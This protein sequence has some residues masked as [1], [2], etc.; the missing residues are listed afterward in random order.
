MDNFSIDHIV[1]CDMEKPFIFISYSSED[2]EYVCRDVIT[3]QSRGY[4][5]WLDE[6]NLDKSEAS[7]KSNALEAIHDYDCKLALF[8]VSKS[9]LTSLNCLEELL[10][11][12]SETT[13]S[14][15][16]GNA[17]KFLAIETDMV[18]IID[19]F[20]ADLYQRVSNSGLDKNEI[21]QKLEALSGFKKEIFNTNEKVRI[22]CR[23]NPNRKSDYYNEIIRYF[24]NGTKNLPI[25]TVSALSPEEEK[26][27]LNPD[28]KPEHMEKSYEDGSHYDGE[29]VKGLRHGNGTMY[30]ATGEEYVGQWVLDKKYYGV[31]EWAANSFLDLTMSDVYGQD[32]LEGSEKNSSENKT[33]NTYAKDV[34]A[35]PAK[36]S[37]YWLDELPHGEG[38]MNYT[39]GD[40][41]KGS[42]K[43]GLHDG[44]GI[45][46][47][48]DG[49]R[50]EGDWV[51]G[52]RH[53]K[54]KTMWS[55]GHIY[56]G[57]YLNNKKDGK[58]YEV[59]SDRS[60]YEGEY[61][62]DKYNGDGTLTMADGSIYKG[63]FVAGLFHGQGEMK[64]GNG[65]HFKGEWKEGSF[66]GE[67]IY[68]TQ[69]GD[70][71]EG[72]FVEMKLQGQGTHQL[73]DGSKYNGDFLKGKYNGRGTM[74]YYNGD[75]YDG[76]WVEGR[77][78]GRG[79]L[80]FSDGSRF[81]GYFNYN[82]IAGNGE[83]RYHNGDIYTGAW[84]NGK[85]NGK[86]KLT[87]ADGKIYEGYFLD[88]VIN[89]KG[90]MLYPDGEHYDG[91]WVNAIRSGKGKLSLP[92]GRKYEGSFSYNHINGRGK[93]EYPNGEFYEGD[94][95]EDLR[96]GNGILI[97]A[98]GRRYKG[99]FSSDHAT[100][101]GT[102]TWPKEK[103]LRALISYDRYE[104]EVKDG[105]RHGIGVMT[106]ADES[107]YDGYWADDKRHG[108]GTLRK[109]MDE[110]A[111][112]I[113]ISKIGRGLMNRLS[114]SKIAG[115]FGGKK[116]G[117]GTI[118]NSENY[119]I[120]EGEWVN[121]LQHG[122]GEI[123]YPDGTIVRGEWR[124]G[125]KIM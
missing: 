55:D 16:M 78:E 5:I 114:D 25:K 57:Q 64:Y 45:F 91:D 26:A 94:W 92:D 106:W 23:N 71:Y 24:P 107:V 18:G 59:F 74:T 39:N 62:E 100:G 96:V 73:A 20:Q 110:N 118:K 97:F 37:G 53:G 98:N 124:D 2:Y 104:G 56:E 28:I 82:A 125:E 13:R 58:G 103:G 119:E 32:N 4:N 76:D 47:E 84:N 122:Q 34:A 111:S 105:L 90:S 109:P 66:E 116:P 113:T 61:L 75:V 11:L 85:R 43:Q 27:L 121:D 108:H 101:R 69:N 99:T 79:I 10:E 89:G 86:G 22:L 83:M 77:R 72:I 41:Y 88:D 68:T 63:R 14:V 93:M 80:T 35:G 65:A 52:K 102:I 21:H 81:D 15:R 17:V 112:M 60:S 1:P 29:S 50:Y 67:G 117:M 87:Y 54:G 3:F 8:Y 12:S 123:R 44:Y 9:S 115:R 48:A 36:Y 31:Q 7:W 6:P 42:F 33:E 70:V 95:M 49:I 51:N 46:A 40:V 19:D 30:Y 120:F 38:T